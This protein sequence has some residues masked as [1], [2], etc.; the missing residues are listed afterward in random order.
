MWIW[1]RGVGKDPRRVQGGETVLR[2]YY[3]FKTLFSIL[4]KKKINLLN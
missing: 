4:N 1:L 3:I 2:I